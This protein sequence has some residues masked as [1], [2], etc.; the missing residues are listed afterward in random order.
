MTRGN[1]FAISDLHL[2][3]ARPKPMDIFGSH[4][5]DHPQKIASAWKSKVTENDI[6]VIGGDVSW[7]MKLESAL[8]DLD[9]IDALPGHKVMIRGNHDFWYPKS[10]A[11]RKGLPQ[12]INALY[13]SSCVVN[14]V[15]F[16]GCK[17]L[18]FEE[19]DI[20]DEAKHKKDLKRQL[21][22]LQASLA[23]LKESEKE[24]SAIVAL[25]HY[26]PAG[27]G[28]AESPITK[29]LEEAEVSWC[30]YGHLHSREDFD[31]AIQG[32]VGKVNYSLTSADYLAFIP[33]CFISL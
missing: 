13:R 19:K 29:L 20:A 6:V 32:K 24:Y 14:G 21:A 1:V 26:P 22:N 23:H 15:A 28:E 3:F 10:A 2:S 30:I 7:A 12:S 8:V 27:P 5:I 4:W 11:K 33:S 31:L 9:F 25:I 16:V 18:S 17:G